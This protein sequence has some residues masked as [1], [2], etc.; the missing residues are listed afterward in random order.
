[1]SEAFRRWL[2]LAIISV[3]G[4]LVGL[5]FGLPLSSMEQFTVVREADGGLGASSLTPYS[6]V[7]AGFPVGQALGAHV[8]GVL[9]AALMRRHSRRPHHVGFALSLLTTAVGAVAYWLGNSLIWIGV[10]RLLQGVG[11]AGLQTT[12]RSFINRSTEKGFVSVVTTATASFVSIFMGAGPAISSAFAT[13]APIKVGGG[14]VIDRFRV[15]GVFLLGATA[16]TLLTLPLLADRINVHRKPLP[17]VAAPINEAQPLLPPKPSTPSLPKSW[18]ALALS[19]IAAMLLIGTGLSAVFAGYETVAA[20]LLARKF[21]TSIAELGNVFL[22]SSVAAAASFIVVAAVL[23]PRRST[24]KPTVSAN[25]VLLLV[26]VLSVM[27]LL[28]LADFGSLAEPLR[29]LTSKC[30]AAADALECSALDWC[31]WNAIQPPLCRI[32]RGGVDA[33]TLVSLAMVNIA[34]VVGRVVSAGQFMTFCHAESSAK[35]AAVLQIVG[36]VA[37]VVAPIVF[38]QLLDAV[39][40]FPSLWPFAISGALMLLVTVHFLVARNRGAS[41]K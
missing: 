24:G 33:V 34:F 15:P 10:G 25:A 39:P 35:A 40:D 19:P 8:S 12:V 29:G 7:S 6:I 1:M 26:L 21:G 41:D 22:W 16:L 31:S 3:I 5:T 30:S 38:I 37:R 13:I 2:D 18:R 14:V 17:L 20:P 28:D 23:T 9:I 4:V 27:A 32:G 11:S 36:S